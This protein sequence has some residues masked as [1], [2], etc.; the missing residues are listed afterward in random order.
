MFFRGKSSKI[1]QLNGPCSIANCSISMAELHRSISK[2]HRG[3][4]IPKPWH[5]DIPIDPYKSINLSGWWFGTFLFYFPYIG[6]DNPNWL[7]FFRGLAQPPTRY[8]LPI[9]F[10][11][12]L[13]HLATGD[14]FYQHELVDWAAMWD[15]EFDRHGWMKQQGDMEVSIN[16]GLP[17]NGWFIMENP[18]INGWFGGTPILGNLHMV[19]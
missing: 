8:H 10:N 4:C 12:L 11:G 14:V 16:G 9:E 7:I 5:H 3:L 6:N 17:R 13:Q 15:D 2:I 1:I 18:S 19:T